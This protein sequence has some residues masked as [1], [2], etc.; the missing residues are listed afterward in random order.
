MGLAYA[1]LGAADRPAE[2]TVAA[3]FSG[4]VPLPGAGP[5]APVRVITADGMPGWQIILI[6]AAAALAAAIAA[7]FLDR[8]RTSRRTASTTR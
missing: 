6:A 2:V 4:R 3:V 5:S 1:D 7:V 8:T